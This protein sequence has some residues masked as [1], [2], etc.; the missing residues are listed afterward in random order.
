VGIRLAALFIPAG[1]AHRWPYTFKINVC[2]V[3]LGSI[4]L[5]P[6]PTCQSHSNEAA[7]IVDLKLHTLDT[8]IEVAVSD[9]FA[10]ACVISSGAGSNCIIQ[11]HR[12]RRSV[13]WTQGLSPSHF[14]NGVAV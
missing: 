12:K 7:G 8:Q 1:M 5:G 6:H 4:C 13:P 14:R 10:K 2:V 9:Q 3:R 11:A